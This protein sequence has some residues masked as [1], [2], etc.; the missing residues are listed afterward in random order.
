MGDR[1]RRGRD[2]DQPGGGY[3]EHGHRGGRGGAGFKRRRDDQG[4]QEDG[5]KPL[6]ASIIRLCDQQPARHSFSSVC[7]FTQVRQ[8]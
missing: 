1:N 7:L 6:L 8:V 5:L 3:T 2:F 4:G